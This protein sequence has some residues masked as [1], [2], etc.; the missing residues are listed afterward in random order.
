MAVAD[1]L[2]DV[3]ARSILIW[4]G[5]QEGGGPYIFPSAADPEQ[6][7]GFEVDLAARVAAELASQPQFMQG[8]WTKL[9]DLLRTAK[10]HVV[11]NG[12]E[13][14]PARA[15]LMATSVP[16]YVYALQLLA[17]GNDTSVRQWSDLKKRRTDGSLRK[18]GVLS[19]S[20]AEDYIRSWAT[21]DELELVAYDGNTDAMREVETEKLDATLQDTPIVAFY[22]SRFPAL[23]P[24][25]VAVAPGY[26]VVCA[27]RGEE[28]L[29]SAIDS[30]LLTLIRTGELERIYR[31]YGIW[32]ERQRELSAIASHARF[33]GGTALGVPS[34][35]SHSDSALTAPPNDVAAPLTKRGLSAARAYAGTLIRAAGVT[36]LLAV[37]AF[38]L[39]VIAG[40]LIALG[41]LY[42]PGWLSKTLGAYVEFLRGTPL[43]LQLFFIF[44][45]LPEVGV[46]VP[47]FATAIV[48]LAVNYSAYEAEI[49]RAGLQ[50]VPRGQLEAA[51][52]LGM[53]RWLA[54]RR[55]VVPQ[56]VRSVIPPVVNDFIALFKDTSV[57]SVVTI[58]ELTKRYSILSMSTGATLELMLMTATL[59]LFMSY[60]LAVASRRI[61]RALHPEAA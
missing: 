15:E 57:C 55:I 18:V 33:F 24:I 60:P 2:D 5:D 8:D 42:G 31:R 6:V 46:R 59:Y 36:V 49:Y 21:P 56:A 13:W 9:P 29:I 45:F 58:V 28:R 32:D 48:G 40:L 44:F 1:A 53:T 52:S 17:R 14:T 7:T 3:R 11:I 19:G 47:A 54:I 27:K 26:Y 23:A 51:L 41:R 61:E 30:A 16:Y 50:A 10:A 43:M 20:A 39:A 4:A 12:F 25:G 35:S 34:A 38:P 37:T 22:G